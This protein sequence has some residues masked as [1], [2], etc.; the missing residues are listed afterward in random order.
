MT[1]LEDWYFPASLPT[2]YEDSPTTI[3]ILNRENPDQW[4][5]GEPTEIEP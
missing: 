3:V 2:E 5:Q 4:V 1:N